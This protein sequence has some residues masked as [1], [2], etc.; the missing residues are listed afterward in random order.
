MEGTRP[1]LTLPEAIQAGDRCHKG[2]GAQKRHGSILVSHQI[3]VASEPFYI[4]AK[5]P[6]TP[7][8]YTPQ[9][10]QHHRVHSLKEI[11][12]SAVMV[13]SLNTNP[14]AEMLIS[15]MLLY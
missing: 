15:V 7:S 8:G 10:G 9:V 4:R 11:G 12:R 2:D 13:Y 6:C 5:K 14:S 3:Y 1:D